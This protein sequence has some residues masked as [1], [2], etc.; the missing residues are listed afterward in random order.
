[1]ERLG[2]QLNALIWIHFLFITLFDA[3]WRKLK[4]CMWTRAVIRCFGVHLK[5]LNL[6]EM[7]FVVVVIV[8][9]SVI[10]F[11]PL[12]ASDSREFTGS[13]RRAI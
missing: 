11:K 3:V 8:Y 10:I 12:F 1:M 6:F 4:P 13:K 2:E 7:D 9:I 5:R